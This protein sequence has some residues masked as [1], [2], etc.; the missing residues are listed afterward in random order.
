M[1]SFI[2][3]ASLLIRLLAAAWS[4]LILWRAQDWRLIFLPVMLLL[5]A[6]QP[7]LPHLAEQ[8]SMVLQV[9]I[10]SVFVATIFY[11]LIRQT[12]QGSKQT[13]LRMILVVITACQ[14]I[15]VVSGE[16]L[17]GPLLQSELS[18]SLVVCLNVVL[19]GRIMDERVRTGLY[20]PL[21]GLPNRILF[22]ERLK[23]AHGRANRQKSY[24]FAV[25]FL[26]LD[27]FKALNDKYG[28]V[29]GD[30]FLMYTAKRL[31]ACL[32]P[33]DTAAR[34]GGDEFAILLGKLGDPAQAQRIVGRLRTAL[35]EPFHLQGQAVFTTA[36]I[37]IALSSTRYER[38][39][40]LLRDADTAMYREKAA[41]KGYSELFNPHQHIRALSQ[42]QLETDLRKAIEGR[43]FVVHYQP[44]VAL[45]R[46]KVTGCEAL[47]RW[48]HPSRGLLSP[49][50]FIP[51]AEGSGLI[52]PM[53]EWILRAACTQSRAWQ[54]AGLAPLTMSV[55]VSPRQ[56]YGQK[57][58]NT[59]S[60]VL[61]DTGLPPHLLELE[62]TESLLMEHPETTSKVL[63]DL[64]KLGVR[65]AV[66][67]FGTGYCSLSYLCRFPLDT[68]KIDKSFVVALNKDDAR[69]GKII[70]A[71][72]AL[73]SSLKL[74]VTAEGI[75]S[76][77]QLTF[78]RSLDCSR[79]QGF[80]FSRALPP[81]AF[82]KYLLQSQRPRIPSKTERHPEMV[83]AAI[84]SA[85]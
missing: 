1:D 49:A 15:F 81:Q 68:L 11:F 54:K 75:E 27:R 60:Q 43:Q 37:G 17:M 78:L 46:G 18:I 19:L 29:I 64:A 10:L 12:L 33:G 61:R 2:G 25:L 45:D 76:K 84:P 16:S 56:L 5:M 21:T 35:E 14:I 7:V 39:E 40:D 28:H 52:L 50:E 72:T 42:L 4:L 80:F 77:E 32:R 9:S 67:D 70:A 65:I 63:K 85:V 82:V 51:I 24:L 83:A 6:A 79:G 31:E 48:N 59:V 62:L 34:L 20:D 26:D 22:M 69:N 66:D 13:L 71:L 57:F 36:S 41:E 8:E 3:I 30:R 74:T 38:P 47:L 73:A 53:G 44:I 23:I 58:V 55:N